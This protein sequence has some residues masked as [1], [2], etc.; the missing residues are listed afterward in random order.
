MSRPAIKAYP[1]AW[2]H[3]M[4]RGRRA[5]DIFLEK[6]DYKVF[7]AIKFRMKMDVVEFPFIFQS[8]DIEGKPVMTDRFSFNC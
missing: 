4:N 2:Y 5:E 7:V 3:V 8:H 6:F 1:R